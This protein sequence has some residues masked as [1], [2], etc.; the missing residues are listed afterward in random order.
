MK[1]LWQMLGFG[2]IGYLYRS[3]RFS[4]CFSFYNILE[5]TFYFFRR[6]V[7]GRKDLLLSCILWCVYVWGFCVFFFLTTVYSLGVI[8]Q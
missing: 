4:K 1:L 6:G 5:A 3:V 7:E 2:K 8:I